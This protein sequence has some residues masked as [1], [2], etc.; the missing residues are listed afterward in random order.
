MYEFVYEYDINIHTP[1]SKPDPQNQTRLFSGR[2]WRWFLLPLQDAPGA[3]SAAVLQ[4]FRKDPI[5]TYVGNTHRNHKRNSLFSYLV[6]FYIK[7]I[8]SG[9]ALLGMSMAR[10][11]IARSRPRHQHGSACASLDMMCNKIFN[12]L[13]SS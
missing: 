10:T 13:S 11:A 12:P 8:P 9:F 7:L 5:S 4:L 1:S 3:A 6:L 2:Q